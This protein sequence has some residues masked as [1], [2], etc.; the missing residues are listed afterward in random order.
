MWG[1][2]WGGGG[3]ASWW[4]H[5]GARRRGGSSGVGVGEEDAGGMGRRKGMGGVRVRR[6][7]EGFGAASRRCW[8]RE[9]R[10]RGVGEGGR[11]RRGTARWTARSVLRGGD[12][13]VSLPTT[14]RRAPMTKTRSGGPPL[15]DAAV[16]DTD[17]ERLV[18][19]LGG[20]PQRSRS[21]PCPTRTTR[22]TPFPTSRTRSRPT[23]SS[24]GSSRGRHRAGGSSGPR[25]KRTSCLDPRRRGGRGGTGSCGRSGVG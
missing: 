16:G 19:R 6:E 17:R 14:T 7:E 15:A 4:R 21:R 12:G 2:R 13:T 5:R 23:T 10:A 9:R 1:R 18:A 3:I 20:S 8:R 11:T 22:A 25:L 24:T